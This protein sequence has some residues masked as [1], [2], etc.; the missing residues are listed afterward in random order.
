M[1]AYLNISC[2]HVKLNYTQ[3]TYIHIYKNVYNSHEI[4]NT[5]TIITQVDRTYQG[6]EREGQTDGFDEA[7]APHC[8]GALSF[9]EIQ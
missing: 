2:L 5:E 7:T 1:Y 8:G 9:A 6:E 4:S 3:N